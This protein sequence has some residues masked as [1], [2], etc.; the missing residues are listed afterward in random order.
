M[1][2]DINMW[3]GKI[4][5][6]CVRWHSAILRN[7][8]NPRIFFENGCLLM[9]LAGQEGRKP[10]ASELASAFCLFDPSIFII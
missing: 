9:F 4:L 6:C 8:R 7:I 5:D 1:R 3:L 10:L 2:L